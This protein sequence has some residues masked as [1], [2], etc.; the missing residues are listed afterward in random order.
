MPLNLFS[1]ESI[2]RI[3]HLVDSSGNVQ[4]RFFENSG[5]FTGVYRSSDGIPHLVIENAKSEIGR[6]EFTGVNIDEVDL[7]VNE[8][9]ILKFVR[10]SP[11]H[12]D[13]VELVV[14]LCNDVIDLFNETGDIK[15][16]VS[17]VLMKW[18]GFL[19]QRASGFM[20]ASE[21]VGLFGEL[22]I[23]NR[24][25]D[26]GWGQRKVIDSWLGPLRAPKDFMTGLI[27]IEVK[28]TIQATSKVE[29]HGLDQLSFE[30]SERL[31]LCHVTL[32]RGVGNSL[33]ELIQSTYLRVDAKM[34]GELSEKLISAGYNPSIPGAIE[35][36][37]SD[38]Y[39]FQKLEAY[40]VEVDFPRI[41]NGLISNHEI[42]KVAYTIDLS[43]IPV[44]E[45]N[46][47]IDE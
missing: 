28:T 44:T 46:S 2:E 23:F 16:S 27:S 37:S 4:G 18:K 13:Y 39:K 45:F 40:P 25:L 17:S 8:G 1:L 20:S 30:E 9:A 33:Y 31:I 22:I 14:E 43:A 32:T 3:P 21:I 34:I 24:L 35:H 15:S 38:R 7:P 10:F 36:Y 19:A 41:H 26:K 29:I 6:L 11:K 47:L 5:L 42:S 12:N